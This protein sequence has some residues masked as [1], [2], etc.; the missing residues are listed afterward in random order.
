MTFRAGEITAPFELQLSYTSNLF[1]FEPLSSKHGYSMS[2][3]NL[4]MF[5][6]G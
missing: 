1:S 6:L 4:I 2:L 5:N 3:K